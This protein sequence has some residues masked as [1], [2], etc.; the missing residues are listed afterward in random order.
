ME[1]GE[2]SLGRAWY[3][4]AEER[5]ATTDHIDQE[6]RQIFF[7]AN[8]AKQAELRVF[9]LNEDP[10]RYAWVNTIQNHRRQASA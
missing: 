9:L 2:Y 3:A 1:K 10:Y 6:L 7:R 5:G 4:K 8:K